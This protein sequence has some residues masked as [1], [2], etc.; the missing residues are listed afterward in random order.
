MSSLLEIRAVY[1]GERFRF[2]NPGGPVI[3]G[4]AQIVDRGNS[5]GTPVKNGDTI[6]IKGEPIDDDLSLGQTYRFMGRWTTYKNKRTGKTEPQ[7]AFN[8]YVLDQPASRDAVVAYLIDAGRT[9]GIGPALAAKLW[10][11][12]GVDA[13]RICRDEPGRIKEVI[14]GFPDSRAEMVSNWLKDRY[15]TEQTSIEIGE[16]MKGRGFPKTAIRA[17]VREWG[18]RAAAVISRNPFK[19]LRIRGCGFVRCDKM[20][21][22]LGHDANRLRRQTFCLWYAMKS[23]GE[24]HTWFPADTFGMRALL[25]AIPRPDLLGAIKLGK[26]I[27]KWFPGRDGSIATQRE[28]LGSL[29]DQGGSLWIA[30]GGKAH[31]ERELAELVVAAMSEASQAVSVTQWVNRKEEIVAVPEFARCARCGKLLTAKTIHVFDGRPYG[32]TC[33]GYVAGVD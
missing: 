2:D 7:F 30:D 25:Q 27:H 12:W 22:D 9:R 18:N 17:A 6:G 4:D 1:R 11:A 23:S 5:N 28:L 33:I 32:P 21:L 20:Y 13:V 29:V 31:D 10:D 26:L 16:L 19:L 3:I 24:G 8:S 14:K 15:A